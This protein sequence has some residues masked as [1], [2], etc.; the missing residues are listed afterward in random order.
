[1]TPPAHRWPPGLH[2]IRCA[3]NLCHV[4]IDEQGVAIMD[5][6]LP[7]DR[8]FLLRGLK[9]L[10]IAPTNVRAILLTH[11]HLDH[12]GNLAWLKS[13]CGAPIYAHPLEQ[14]HIDGTFPY[15]GLASWC[16][17]L[18]RAGRAILGYKAAKIDVP[19]ADDDELPFWGGLRVVHLPGHT[20]GHCGFYSGKHRLLF[21]ADLF[22]S[23]GFSVHLPP[24]ILNSAPG[25]MAA[26][27][28]RANALDAVGFVPNHYDY[29]DQE[30]HRRRFNAL[31][32]NITER[33][34]Q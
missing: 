24:S 6:G 7:C 2:A 20:D 23:Y 10:N 19:I 34:R 3:M 1:M 18:E 9:R 26:S 31:L 27:L 21:S 17:R 13:W 28:A 30:L 15:V 33:R 29:R 32:L 8:W 11:G 14:P 16:G 4:L 12:A 22:A 25:K 5:T